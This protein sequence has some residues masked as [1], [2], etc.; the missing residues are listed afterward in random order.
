MDQETQSVNQ[1]KIAFAQSEH[2][3][4]AFAILKGCIHTGALMGKSEY[5][6][7]VNAATMDAQSNMLLKFADTIDF[8]KRGGLVNSENV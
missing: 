6:T 4:A 5:E 1:K 8:I 3:E 7:I 2:V